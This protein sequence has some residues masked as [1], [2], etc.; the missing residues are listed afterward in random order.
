MS[1]KALVEALTIQ[2]PPD[3]LD[4][5]WTCVPIALAS[6]A[7]WGRKNMVVKAVTLPPT[8]TF[9]VRSDDKVYPVHLVTQARK[10]DLWDRAAE[11][12]QAEEK[13]IQ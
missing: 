5:P 13:K 1:D 4:L 6:K 7:V 9:S 12:H 2:P 8:Y 11:K 3:I 10:L